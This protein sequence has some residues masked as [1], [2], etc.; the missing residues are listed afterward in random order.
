MLDN[1][2]FDVIKYY[3]KKKCYKNQFKYLLIINIKLKNA[4]TKANI[5]L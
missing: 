5:L 2:F 1:I 4:K 3:H